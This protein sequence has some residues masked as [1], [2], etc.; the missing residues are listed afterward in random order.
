MG[1]SERSSSFRATVASLRCLGGHH[2]FCLTLTGCGGGAAVGG[3]ISLFDDN[4]ADEE[5]STAVGCSTP[6][7]VGSVVS[8]F[9]SGFAS[10]AVSG[11]SF[12]MSALSGSYST[13]RFLLYSSC[14]HF[15]FPPLLVSG[16]TAT[17]AAGKT[18]WH[19]LDGCPFDIPMQY[20]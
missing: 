14:R 11:L 5:E 9:F 18:D 1:A 15:A 20:L 10:V 2:R 8:S 4:A 19:P 3:S 6:C 7:T 17:R 16:P 12:V 13:S